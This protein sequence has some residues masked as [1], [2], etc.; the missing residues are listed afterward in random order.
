[1]IVTM[2][3]YEL[4]CKVKRALVAGFGGCSPAALGELL[5]K[6]VFVCLFY[7]LG[8]LTMPFLFSLVSDS[9]TLRFLSLKPTFIHAYV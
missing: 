2:K 4:F 1:M 3:V 6:T 5:E 8:S 9:Y 7:F